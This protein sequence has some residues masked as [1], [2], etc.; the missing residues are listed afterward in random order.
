M[1]YA[2]LPCVWVSIRIERHSAMKEGFNVKSG[3]GLKVSAAPAE[4]SVFR[5]E[6]GAEEGS[7]FRSF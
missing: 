6:A 3:K 2:I 7:V 5:A 1:K 4:E